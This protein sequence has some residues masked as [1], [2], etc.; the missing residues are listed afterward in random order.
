VKKIKRVDWDDQKF[1]NNL[2]DATYGTVYRDGG[3][4]IL[5]LTTV[6]IEY[7][8]PLAAFPS[9]SENLQYTGGCTQP[10]HP[11]YPQGI[12]SQDTLLVLEF[13]VRSRTV[14]YGPRSGRIFSNTRVT[15][16]L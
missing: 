14:L 7:L 8:R 12:L 9:K 15:K 13:R 10:P 3:A 6:F 1:E 16:S 4:S 5:S 11:A 2:G